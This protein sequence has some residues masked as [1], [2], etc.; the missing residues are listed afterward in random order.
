MFDVHFFASGAYS[1]DANYQKKPCI[2]PMIR[3]HTYLPE[4]ARICSKCTFLEPK[5]PPADKAPMLNLSNTSILPHLKS[6]CLLMMPQKIQPMKVVMLTRAV[7][8]LQLRLA[9]CQKRRGS[10]MPDC[11]Q[12][13]MLRK[14]QAL[15]QMLSKLQSLTR[16]TLIHE[17]HLLPF[18]IFENF[19]D[20]VYK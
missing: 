18:H 11:L 7:I 5:P 12:N 10:N 15:N 8:A 1:I 4:F 14:I 9:D 19:I 20:I 6:R 16:I 13:Q 17:W 2:C 3:S